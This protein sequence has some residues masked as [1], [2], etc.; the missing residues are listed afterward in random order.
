[1]APSFVLSVPAVIELVDAF[2]QADAE[3]EE[4]RPYLEAFD[5]V[6]TGGSADDGTIHSRTAV[7][8]K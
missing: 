6:V 3:F 8:L 2:G 1:M 4:A 7:T 5:T